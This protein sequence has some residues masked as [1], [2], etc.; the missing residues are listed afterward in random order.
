MPADRPPDT[1]LISVADDGMVLAERLSPADDA[2]RAPR[3]SFG[4]RGADT[5]GKAEGAA[6]ALLPLLQRDED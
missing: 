4:Y 5:R 1:F 2:P 6:F 3:A